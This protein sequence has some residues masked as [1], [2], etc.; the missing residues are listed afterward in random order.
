MLH[1]KLGG[2]GWVEAEGSRMSVEAQEGEMG[3]NTVVVKIQLCVFV[4]FGR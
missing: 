1:R 4:G 2:S 3:W